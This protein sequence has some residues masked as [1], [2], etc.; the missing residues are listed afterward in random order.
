MIFTLENVPKDKSD[1]QCIVK[2]FNNET[3]PL[4]FEQAVN[5]NEGR[6]KFFYFFRNLTEDKK[7]NPSLQE[8]KEKIQFIK[9]YLDFLEAGQ[10]S[11][12][13]F[14]FRFKLFLNGPKGDSENSN[15]KNL[16][17]QLVMKDESH[18]N[19]EPKFS[20]EKNLLVGYIVNVY[21]YFLGVLHYVFRK[22]DEHM[23]EYLHG[24]HFNSESF[25]Y[26][27]EVFK[28]GY[29]RLIKL[30]LVRDSLFGFF[31]NDALPDDFSIGTLDV[32]NQ[33]YDI[34]YINLLLYK[35]LFRNDNYQ[36]ISS[37]IKFILIYIVWFK[38]AKVKIKNLIQ[39]LPN[40]N[41]NWK[42]DLSKFLKQ[43]N[44]YYELMHNTFIIRYNYLLEG[45]KSK[46]LESSG[47]DL[48][49]VMFFIYEL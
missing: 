31:I 2:G 19:F 45:E 48:F 8:F 24:S 30:S 16:F 26:I 7:F 49:V 41:F 9:Q 13:N 34:N 10:Q 14:N 15:L 43:L 40:C 36:A 11:N 23:R 12:Y 21:T 37:S 6:N 17:D 1:P 35:I 25:E 46:N 20:L 27:I 22:T 44:V 33:I 4:I 42:A 18:L 3:T 28:L 47:N 5:I 32:F 39:I 29:G 38:E